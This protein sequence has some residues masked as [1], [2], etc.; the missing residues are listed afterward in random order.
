MQQCIETFDSIC[1]VLP[2]SQSAFD[3]AKTS[4]LKQI[5]QRRYVRMAPITSFV[6]YRE[7]G[8]DHDYW[9]DIYREAQQLTLDDVVAFQQEHIANRTYRYLILGNEKELDMEYLNTCGT[10]KRLTLE[11]I[12]VY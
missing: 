3:N 2:L 8:W 10:I 6:L 12:F 1:N 4:L 7:L 5:E 11:D 9:E